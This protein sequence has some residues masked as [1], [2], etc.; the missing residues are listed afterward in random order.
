MGIKLQLDRISNLY[1]MMSIARYNIMY[2]SKSLEE[3]SLKFFTI[4][5]C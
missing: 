3:R 4:M 1:D 5:K 2:I